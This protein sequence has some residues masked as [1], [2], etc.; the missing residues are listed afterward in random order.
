[1]NKRMATT[2]VM[3]LFASVSLFQS[4]PASAA[5][6]EGVGVTTNN[7]L[8]YFDLANYSGFSSPTLT[9]LSG[10][11][12]NFTTATAGS[13]SLPSKT[14]S[15]GNY[16]NFTGSGSANG[17]YLS[18][19]SLPTGSSAWSGL[20]VSF[21]ANM[22]TATLVERVFDF[23]NAAQS[24]NIWVGVGS[25][26]E[27]AIEVFNGSAS[28]GWCRSAQ[29]A[30]VNNEWAH[31][32]V[33]L[34]G[35]TCK[36]YKNNVL[37]SSNNYSYLPQRNLTLTRNYIGKSNWVDPYFEGG[38]GD[39]AIY[40][41]ALSDAE[42]LQNYNAQTDL[43]APNLNAYTL[44][45]Y[46]TSTA[47]GTFDFSGSPTYFNLSGLDAAQFRVTSSGVLSFDALKNYELS[48][49]SGGNR[50]YDFAVRLT[51]ANG[52]WNSWN[53]TVV[54]RDA[55]EATSLTQPVLSATPYKGLA[56]TIT[57]TPTGDG[58][59]I[60]G[61]LTY[62]MAGKRIVG[63]YKKTYSGTGNATCTWK[64]TTM[65]FREITVT[66]T[67]TNTSFTAAT[68]KKTFLVLRRTTTR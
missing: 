11:G 9:D 25:F 47:I 27:M 18:L 23:G 56:L 39:L 57:V 2:L 40:K 29:N 24:D 34:D 63:C 65:G 55:I 42:R 6:S 41:G 60:P 31:W 26:N 68:T 16:L 20:S 64:P 1:M 30:I 49:D 46:E 35:S 43:A 58:T 61:R 36:W 52:N 3:L 10:N 45:G 33:V 51:D 4:A 50:T 53:F 67:P 62:L 44:N 5:V 13:G 32:T 7:L 48:S 22:G 59:S 19:A 14:G 38:I 54:L 12:Y 8:M 66:F 15:N 17:G 28:P 21:Y 37:S